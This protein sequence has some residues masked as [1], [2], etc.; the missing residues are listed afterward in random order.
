[1][2]GRRRLVRPDRHTMSY[3]RRGDDP[4]QLGEHMSRPEDQWRPPEP[5]NRQQPRQPGSPRPSS[6]PRWLPWIIVA[7]LVTLVLVWQAAPGGGGSSA[8]LEY[9]KFL[10]LVKQD[11]IEQINYESSSGKIS[12]E[13]KGDFQVDGQS[14]FTTQAQPDGLPDAD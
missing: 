11:R 12:G 7:V 9:S 3:L 13:F 4:S 8:S 5:P 1:M 6:R 14:K 2:L 10:D